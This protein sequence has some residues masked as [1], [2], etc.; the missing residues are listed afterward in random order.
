[1][2]AGLTVSSAWFGLGL[3]P[4]AA[5]GPRLVAPVE[6]IVAEV[7]VIGLGASGLEAC[8]HLASRGVDVVGLDAR[9]VAAG[10][11][12]ANGGFLLAGMARFH[13][14]AVAHWGREAAV[15]WYA[16]T[17]EELDRA[18]DEE[19]TARRVGSLRIAAEDT[20]IDDIHRQA[21]ALDADGF[22]VEAFDDGDRRGLLVPDD[23]VV[24]PVAR[25]RRLAEEAVAAGAR[26]H[27]PAAV[28]AVRGGSFGLVDGP[29]VSADH[30]LIAVDGGLEALVPG[31]CR[32]ARLQ[33]LATAPQPVVRTRPEYRRH[34]LDYLQQLP[35][36]EVLLGGGRDVGGDG[37]WLE[38]GAPAE[39]G[40]LVQDHLDGL[41][42]RLG[43]EAAVTHRWAA[44]AA[45]TDDRLPV[46]RTVAP[47]VHAVGG[48]SGH[49]NVLGTLLARTAVDQIL[50]D[51]S[52]RLPD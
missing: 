34:G 31:V 25:C 7:A 11:A 39:P 37:E 24:Q 9:G 12:G 26:L 6:P 5:V 17:L 16:R 45:F 49:G 8:R 23:G 35:S 13:H 20:E 43:I 14:D 15:R 18:F 52:V 28:R 27:A 29:V 36:G 30:V 10:A 40:P 41:L 48:Y 38:P 33:M 21:E 19:P 2:T 47:G 4:G 44:R 1:M 22:A 42:G 46:M 51:G 3:P 32:T 50:T